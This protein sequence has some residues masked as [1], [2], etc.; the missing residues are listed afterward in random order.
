MKLNKDKETLDEIASLVQY[1][2]LKKN[3]ITK[4]VNFMSR[5]YHSSGYGK[6]HKDKLTSYVMSNNF[7]SKIFNQTVKMAGIGYVSTYPENRG[8]GDIS[9][10]MNEILIDLHRENIPLSNLAPWSESFYRQYG[11]ENTIYRK[12]LEFRSNALHYFKPSKEGKIIRGTL[13]DE[14][15]ST[16]VNKMYTNQLNSATERNTVIREKWWWNRFNTYYPDRYVAIYLDGHQNP[17]GYMFYTLSNNS[18]VAD[19][20]Y[21]TSQESAINLLSFMGGHISSS[22][23]FK[24][25]TSVE[26]LLEDLFPNQG[27]ITVTVHP[28]MMSRIIDFQTIASCI[29]METREPIIIE[30]TDDKQCEWNNKKWKFT[31]LTDKTNCEQTIKP[32]DYTASITNWTK[33]LLGRL[34]VDQAV[35]LGIIKHLT[36]N[37]LILKK[38]KVSFYDYF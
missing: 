17:K 35:N 38:G 27:M 25:V 30:V 11:Y 22:D 32:P 7:K 37:K 21:F 2:F 28:Y 1:A 4:D 15:I 31:P 16:L 12:I 36:S 13:K 26:S 19:E 5:Y 6:F 24:I 23:S 18:F 33:V 14:K 20:F 9:K 10:I 34:T 29:K 8:H 3:D